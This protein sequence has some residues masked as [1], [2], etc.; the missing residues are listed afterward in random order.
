MPII[1]MVSTISA[2]SSTRNAPVAAYLES[3]TL[4]H[5]TGG[6]VRHAFEGKEELSSIA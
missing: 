2:S 6:G 5:R 4:L 1:V 3:W